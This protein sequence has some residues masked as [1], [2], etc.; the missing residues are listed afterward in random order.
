MLVNSI[1]TKNNFHNYIVIKQ[2]DNTSAIEI[3]L[4]GANGSILSDL[5]QS[6]TLTILDEVDQ[7]IRQKTKEQ[8]VNGTVT[9]RVTNDLKT[10]PHTLEITTA[11][12]QK[13]PSNHDFKIFV[14]YTHDESELRVINNL[15]REEALA[16]IDQS[17]KEFISENTE[18]YIDKVATSKWLY[19]NNFKPKEVVTTFNDLPKDAELKEL[20]GVTDENA[21][22]V[23][24]GAKWIKQSNINFDGLNDLKRQFEGLE[25]NV[26]YYGVKPDG[27][28]H[29]AKIQDLV[30]RFKD[31][32]FPQG[33][34]IISDEIKM[35]HGQSITTVGPVVFD[36]NN[37]VGASG[38]S[39]LKVTN[40]GNPYV[41]LSN[42]TSDI[43][44]GDLN[45]TFS[46]SHNL[47][48]GDVICLYDNTD[49]SYNSSRAYYRK[50]EFAKVASI[51]SDTQVLLDAGVFDNYNATSNANFG[52]Y[53]MNV[54]KFNV[55][56]D[57]TVVQGKSGN[58][59]A[60]V[61]ER[62]KDFNLANFKV[63]AN[64]GSYTALQF[65]QCFNTDFK[66][67][68]IQE[69]LSGLGGDYGLAILNCQHFRGDG[70]FSAS[71]HGI[72]HGGYSDLCSIVNRDCKTSGTVKT[73]G[74]TM[75]TAWNC[76]GNVEFVSFDGNCYG[77]ATIAG[78][79]TKLRGNYGATTQGIAIT[80][81]EMTGFNHDLSG[82]A[83]DSIYP[84]TTAGR[85]VIDFGA[86][87]M[88]DMDNFKGGTFNLS[89]ILINAPLADRAVTFRLRNT[90]NT[91]NTIRMYI[92]LDNSTYILASATTTPVYISNL[93]TLTFTHVTLEN[94]KINAGSELITNVSD[95][96]MYDKKGSVDYVTD[97]SK[98]HVTYR[99]DFDKRYPTG[100][101][102][103]LNIQLDRLAV[104]TVIINARQ[105]NISNTGFNIGIYT[106]SS[107]NF[108]S[109][110]SGKVTW[111]AK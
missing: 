48:I 6:C 39:V 43:K 1:K 12:G 93:N 45:L 79:N 73:T 40:E 76:H 96:K 72:T 63:Y 84:I 71:R 59:I 67:V 38:S 46:S 91:D 54:G 97:T 3:L 106:A 83:I 102:P 69:K 77:G 41:K 17:I 68:A 57:L 100:Y 61:F 20:R 19:E 58:Y 30:K 5:N 2:S 44:K 85:S 42:V 74:A 47:V 23:Y 51:I 111:S 108:Y 8:I 7:L 65:K 103:E 81:T 35:I 16:E 78:N 88:V 31:L 75:A 70:Y 26:S 34:Y 29:T 15:S 13:F 66:G 98:N 4:C 94:T 101:I 24:D 32:V 18:E 92:R 14:S 109:E 56:G 10:N 25:V 11:D 9:F 55:N 104:G 87:G 21:V 60:A 89:N 27:Q 95:L 50:G 62:V 80:C 52:I 28:D 99:V 49:Y 110:V 90:K 64:N 82:I 86:G 53:K 107:S 37:F 36:G 33:K 22:Y 105:Y